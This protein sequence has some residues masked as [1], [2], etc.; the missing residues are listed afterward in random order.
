MRRFARIAAPGDAAE[1]QRELDFLEYQLNEID[2]LAP[3]EHELDD[4]LIEE[5]MLSDV[6]RIR[7]IAAQLL[8][9]LRW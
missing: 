7:S 6:D 5:R 2:Q 8:R 4:L 9:C 1:R 3:G